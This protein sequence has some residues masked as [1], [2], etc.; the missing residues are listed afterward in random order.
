MKK[1]YHLLDQLKLIK[2]ITLGH[3]ICATTNIDNVQEDIFKTV[4]H[5]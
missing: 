5:K 3:V 2:Y 1:S 4:D